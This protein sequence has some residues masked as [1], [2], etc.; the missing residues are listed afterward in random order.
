PARSRRPRRRRAIR[1]TAGR[2]RPSSA[3]RGRRSTARR[4][5]GPGAATT[6]SIDT[7]ERV[8]I[9]LG[10]LAGYS[11]DG[12]WLLGG[13]TPPDRPGIYAL[14]YKPHPDT[15]PDPH[16]VL[17]VGRSDNLAAEGFSSAP[18]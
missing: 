11:F 16:A 8:M 17:Y 9:R 7:R 2:R 1:R 14:M 12:P 18:A 4:S 3:I 10:S 6:P 5:L 13:W 15:E